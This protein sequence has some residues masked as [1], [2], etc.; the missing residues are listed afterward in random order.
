MLRKQVAKSQKAK[1]EWRA[2]AKEM[3]STLEEAKVKIEALEEEKEAL[4]EQ[5]DS[6]AI[7]VIIKTR[8]DLMMEFKA[9]K[10]F[11]WKL[12]EEIE[13]WREM[14]AEVDDEDQV[15]EE[16]EHEILEFAKRCI[17]LI[18]E[19]LGD[20]RVDLSTGYESS[21]AKDLEHVAP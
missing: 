3:T 15:E 17:E 19:V 7:D 11:E 5:L 14:E 6:V 13:I 4:E 8:A 2:K 9:R 20:E 1:K 18:D 16:L 10:S 21:Q 12:D